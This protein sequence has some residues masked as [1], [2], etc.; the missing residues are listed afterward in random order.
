MFL[1]IIQR[2]GVRE[3]IDQHQLK[4]A[5][6]LTTA[7]MLNVEL[8]ASEQLKQTTLPALLDLT[9]PSALAAGGRECQKALQCPTCKRGNHPHASA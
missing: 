1:R 7:S 2:Y 6:K 4:A 9:S 3:D 8:A 5:T